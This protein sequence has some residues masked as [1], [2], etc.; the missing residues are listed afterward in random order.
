VWLP[1]QSGGA[2][3]DHQITGN[4]LDARIL[5]DEEDETRIVGIRGMA[6]YLN[7]VRRADT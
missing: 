5:G 3:H 4:Q 1:Q 7:G 2:D 6:I